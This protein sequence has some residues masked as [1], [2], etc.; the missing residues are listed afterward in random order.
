MQPRV[1][2]DQLNQ[3]SNPDDDSSA[4]FLSR[5]VNNFLNNV[6]NVAREMDQHLKTSDFVA[7][8]KLAHIIKGTSGNLGLMLLHEY[9]IELEAQAKQ[10]DPV[11]VGEWIQKIKDEVPQTLNELL[12]V[13]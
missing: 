5:L 7:I 10:E 11:A 8:A 4:E 1:N 9:C 13:K 6:P 2:R 12:Q 3:W